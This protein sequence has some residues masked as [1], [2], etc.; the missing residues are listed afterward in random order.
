MRLYMVLGGGG[1]KEI[2]NVKTYPPTPRKSL[3][4]APATELGFQIRRSF[5]GYL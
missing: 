5:L 3:L 1:G 2:A 4:Y